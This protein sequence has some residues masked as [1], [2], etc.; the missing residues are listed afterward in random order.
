MR[1]VLLFVPTQVCDAT[2]MFYFRMKSYSSSCEETFSKC[3]IMF[4]FC[5]DRP[6]R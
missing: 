2:G 4:T 3:D 5:F 1:V 6:R